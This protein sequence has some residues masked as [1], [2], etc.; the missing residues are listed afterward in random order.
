MATM[1]TV[2]HCY[3]QAEDI[4]ERLRWLHQG[5]ELMGGVHMQKWGEAGG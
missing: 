3:E 4:I 1:S 2:V 5:G